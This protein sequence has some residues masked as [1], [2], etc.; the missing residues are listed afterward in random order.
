MWLRARHVRAREAFTLVVIRRG[1]ATDVPRV[2]YVR[3]G[4]ISCRETRG[5]SAKVIRREGLCSAPQRSSIGGS[6]VFN[7]GSQTARRVQPSATGHGA[8]C[9]DRAARTAACVW[10]R[11]LPQPAPTRSG[12]SSRDV[13][14][15]RTFSN[16]RQLTAI[17][18]Q[19]R[20]RR[21]GAV[22][23]ESVEGLR[24]EGPAG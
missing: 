1:G 17:K 24:S 23:D 22:D 5:S 13:R 21:F 12:G 16:S 19:S 6:T 7:G 2:S 11:V 18:A 8:P 3:S 9:V 14:I 4:E 20:V 15:A 10:A